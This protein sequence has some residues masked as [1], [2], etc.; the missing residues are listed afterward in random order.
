MDVVELDW[1]AD[2]LQQNQLRT[3]KTIV[4]CQTIGGCNEVYTQLMD[5]LGE[6]AF[7]HRKKNSFPYRMIQVFYADVGELTKKH[8]LTQFPKYES[9][10]RILI[11]TNAFGT[12]IDVPDIGRVVHWGLSRNALSYWQEVGRAGRSG[13]NAEGY[14]YVVPKY[15]TV[16]DMDK[17]FILK[18]KEVGGLQIRDKGTQRTK[19]TQTVESVLST[20][21]VKEAE[22]EVEK[23]YCLRSLILSELV[24]DKMKELSVLNDKICEKDKTL[25]CL[26]QCCTLCRERCFCESEAQT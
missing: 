25:C 17:S 20:N 10:I 18:I 21:E 4:Y 22:Q 14:L 19:S 9:N 11:A 16:K 2:D 5:K 8:I 24:L 23:N 1:L 6:H 3:T 13:Q 7:A 15:F 26:T 12:G